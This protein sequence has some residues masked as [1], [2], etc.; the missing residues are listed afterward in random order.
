MNAKVLMFLVGFFLICIALS[1][2][3]SIL[4]RNKT[5]T[6]GFADAPSQPS[7]P[8]QPT[9]DCSSIPLSAYD[10]PKVQSY[11]S[12]ELQYA[13]SMYS[14]GMLNFH[15]Q[16]KDLWLAG[17]AEQQMAIAALLGRYLAFNGGSAAVP[18]PGYIFTSNPGNYTTQ[19]T[20][21]TELLNPTKPIDTSSPVYPS[22]KAATAV[23][24]CTNPNKG[25]VSTD[26][27]PKTL[28]PLSD[29]YQYATPDTGILPGPRIDHNAVN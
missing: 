2:T 14:T 10:A 26:D 9:T 28:P 25:W 17:S 19:I 4:S 20:G 16:I 22:F 5:K 7:Q 3:F 15:K 13:I 23:A 27:F 24:L 29:L 21:A 1:A 11:L 8:T 12:K 18:G 6:E